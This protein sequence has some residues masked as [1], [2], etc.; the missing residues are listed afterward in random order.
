[1][2]ATEDLFSI[3][4][5]KGYA[6]DIGLVTGAH[7]A[8]SLLHFIR[9]PILT[10]WL[11]A[12]LYGT[13]SL[14]WVTIVLITPVAML[15]LGTAFIRFL[16][17]ERDVS[18]IREGFLSMVFTILA[19]GAFFSIVLIL[20]SDLIASSVLGD[21][22]NSSHL[23]RLA[24]FMILTQAI[25]EMSIAFFRT[26]RQLKL[27]STLMAM[28]AVVQ[29]GL[30]VCFLLLGGEIRG[31]IFAVL[32]SDILCIAIA[33]SV[34][35][36]QMGFQLPKFTELKDYLKYGLP[37]VPSA[38]ILWIIQSSDRYM[39]GYFMQAEDVGIYTS[40]YTL[41]YIISL[42]LRPIQ[43]VLLP[44]ISKSYD[45][46]DMSKTKTYLKF[47][48]KYLMML[49]IP[50]AFGL[51]ILASPLL[52]LLTTSEF[53]SGNVVIP[54]IACGILFYG[55]YQVC[56]HILY[57]VKKT[58]WLVRLLGISAALNIAL[59]LLLI[60]KLGIVGAAVATLIAF[61]SLGILT[62]VISF[63][64]FKFDLGYFFIIKSILA[65]AVMSTA[66]WLFKPSGVTEVIIA[67]LLGIIIY[68]AMILVLKGFNKRELYLLKDLARFKSRHYQ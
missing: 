23:V 47:S 34:A 48:L 41:T 51:S 18:R 14:I 67:I 13:W 38:A 43:V 4:E 55:Y 61:A 33:F 31:V 5:Y 6:R 58:Y 3:E 17:V 66:I 25:S 53:V 40:A 1:M 57:L 46:G 52:R 8:V 7:I 59:N 42:F 44:T 9:L 29:V 62:I 22:N 36:R 12:S 16:A 32:A 54:L 2:V 49:S 26:F 37:L 50:A 68:F 30:M 24:S 56:M 35:L 10:K 39:I 19:A 20:C 21:I 64:H 27:Y 15:G 60:P 63:R 45:D 11:G 65:S 28:K